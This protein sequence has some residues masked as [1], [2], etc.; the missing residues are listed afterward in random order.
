MIGKLLKRQIVIYLVGAFSCSAVS[1]DQPTVSSV[2]YDFPS[3]TV[4][5][6]G[7]GFG[8]GPEVVLF[9]DFEHGAEVGETVDYTASD[10]PWS[11]IHQYYPPLY[12]ERS[13]SGSTSALMYDMAATRARQLTKEFDTPAQS[14]FVSH[15]VKVPDGTYFPGSNVSGLKSFSFDSS[16]KFSWLID[17]D[18]GTES[19]NVCTPTH[20]GDGIFY[21]AG[22]D[23]NIL[24]VD[25]NA[26][27]SWG[28]WNRVTTTLIAN[29]NSP[30][31]DGFVE[32]S[33][34][35][36]E[37][38]VYRQA[39]NR[40]VYDEDGSSVKQF[41]K[42]NIPG[43][44]RDSG[45]NLV[46]TLYDDIYV[47]VGQNA[48]KRIELTDGIDYATISMA[49]IQMAST[50]TDNR[51]TFKPRNGGLEDIDSSFIHFIDERGNASFLNAFP[52]ALPRPPTLAQ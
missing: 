38:G 42:I 39:E 1:G 15:W 33:A 46:Q 34:L 51:I 45:A 8:T 5:I 9:D 31:T 41:Q 40:A 48:A 22:N 11:S 28:A 50:W 32:F 18:T 3:K 19:S 44:I 17:E 52:K 43:W 36:R 25:S 37:F 12:D 4:T 13:H 49:S 2:T 23:I 20:A 6:L 16:W 7:S 30:T 14:V 35:S 29:E 21:I 10:L 47:A 27:W 26:W 24:R